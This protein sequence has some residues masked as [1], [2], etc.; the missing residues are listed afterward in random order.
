MP[1]ANTAKE[2]YI[3]ISQFGPVFGINYAYVCKLTPNS[4]VLMHNLVSV[5]ETL[6]VKIMV[7]FDKMILRIVNMYSWSYFLLYYFITINSVS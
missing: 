6:V 3:Y 5:H 1:D 2:H 4:S 7:E